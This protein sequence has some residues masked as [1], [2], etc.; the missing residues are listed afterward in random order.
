MVPPGEAGSKLG[1]ELQVL[2]GT[3]A[4]ILIGLVLYW[5][6]ARRKQE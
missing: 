1:F 3:V 6:G 5:R 2:V 4:S